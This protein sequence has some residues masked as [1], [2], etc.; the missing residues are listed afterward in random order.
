MEDLII[1][2]IV[3]TLVMTL[4][5]IA[6][7]GAGLFTA[8][9]LIFLG[10]NPLA[11][12]A[13]S[14]IT[15]LSVSVG[16]GFEYHR[17]RILNLKTQAIF[18][19]AG[20][21]GAIIGSSLLVR[22]SSN[23]ELIQK[24]LGYVILLIGLPLL[25]SRNLGLETKTRSDRSKSFGLFVLFIL[26]IIASAMSGVATAYLFVFMLFFGMTAINAAVAKRSIQLVA[27]SISLII[28]TFAGF[29]DYKLGFI[30]VVTSLFGG[31]IGAKI[32]IKKGN[33]FVINVFAILSAVLAIK[34]VIG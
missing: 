21:V 13:T 20:G 23:E 15:G 24:M 27:Q 16:A 30:A 33:K 34:L 7:G 31:Y 22:F 29:I 18:M 32:A 26:S 28:F 19:A 14:K 11:A 25:L 1:F 6:G 9:F 12:I 5:G 2:A 4:S 17:E 8:P 10:Y 3:N